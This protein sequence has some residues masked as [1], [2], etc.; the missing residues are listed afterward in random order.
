MDLKKLNEDKKRKEKYNK[1]K[2]NKNLLVKKNKKIKLLNFIL[3]NKLYKNFKYNKKFLCLL[4]KYKK[5]LPLKYKIRREIKK[6][7]LN[8]AYIT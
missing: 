4:L 7:L 3:S 2:E 5:L 1:I 8:Y 6:I